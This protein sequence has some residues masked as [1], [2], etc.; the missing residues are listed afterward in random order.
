MLANFVPNVSQF[1]EGESEGECVA[2]CTAQVKLMSPP[3]RENTH[4]AEDIDQLADQ[5][6][7]QVT[8]GTTEAVPIS[9]EE[10][11]EILRQQKL[12]FEEIGTDH[13]SIGAALDAGCPV[14][15]QGAESGFLDTQNKSPYTWNTAGIDHAI[16]AIENTQNAYR[17][18]DSANPQST[19]PVYQKAAM[20]LFSAIKIIP[21]WK[22]IE[23]AARDTWNST[24]F[25]YGGSPL[26]YATG[27]AMSWRDIYVHQ[28]HLM[29]PPTTREFDSVDWHDNPIT[30]Q[31]FGIL[32]CEWSKKTQT[33]LWYKADGGK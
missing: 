23:K 28:E 3:W 15:I 22:Y 17:V 7:A 4:T 26:P 18:V 27:I 1:E 25:L 31:F 6:Y 19:F 16:V 11:K 24:A 32:R 21:Y 10:F 5:I 2:F 20:Q 13:S 30:V 9:V 14:V 12:S 8:G 29:P 33:P